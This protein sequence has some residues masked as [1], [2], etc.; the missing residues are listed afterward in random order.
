[1]NNQEF[2]D[3][4]AITT[5]DIVSA[6]KLNPEQANRFIDYVMDESVL[7]GMTRLVRF[8]P[9]QLDIDKI[10]V[11][12][13]V[14]VPKAEAVDPGIRRGVNTSKVSL[15]PKDIMVPFEISDTFQRFNIEGDDVEDHIIRMMATQLAN[16]LDE[17]WLNGN[18]LGPA[19]LESDI[20]DGGSSTQYVKDS[21][22]GL[23]DGFL[24][25]AEAGH[26]VDAGN[27]AL[28]GGVFNKAIL[29]MPTKFRK[30]RSLIKFLLSPDHEQAYREEVSQ[31]MTPAGDNA[32][33]SQ[34]NL[35]PFGVE[36][37]P[38]PLLSPNP[39][40]VENSVANTD[41]TTPTQL[42]FQ[43]VSSL[44]LTPTTLASIPTA[45]YLLSTDY[46][47]VLA[48]GTW[49]RL[50]AAGIG[51]G[52]TI[53]AT[54]DSR[55]KMLLTNPSNLI[56]GIG[57]DIRIERDRNIYKSVNEFAITVSVCCQVENT[58]ALVLVKN[59]ADPNL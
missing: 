33:Q 48:S 36:M 42:S 21:Y 1:M 17:L 19:V 38:V 29:G 41:G 9:D 43:P 18:S 12:N 11:G 57:M 52:A 58:D 37:M 46:T 44:I 51:S 23:F 53:K 49:T 50:G 28:D 16:D 31:R 22:L 13:R 56:I 6:G 24:K 40:T 35:T 27:A 59:I 25:L 39:L 7:K 5:A 45:A 55:G 3:R 4:A 14:A 30:N 54:Y 2:L 47:Q 32:L 20:I 8:R 15:F 26:V 10:G 34:L